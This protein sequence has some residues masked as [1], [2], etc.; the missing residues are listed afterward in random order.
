MSLAN[1]AGS[2]QCFRMTRQDGG[3]YRVIAFG[4]RLEIRQT[5]ER[6]FAFDCSRDEFDRV[7][8]GYFDLRTDYSPLAGRIDPG[9]RFLAAA[10]RHGDGLRILRQ[11]PWE[12]TVS[13]IISQ[14]KSLP[15]IRSAVEALC[16]RFGD[17]LEDRHGVYR[18]F[19]APG[20]IAG[21]RKEDLDACSLGYRS[22]YVLSAA[23][24]AASGGLDFGRMAALDDG[25]LRRELMRIDGVGPKIAD[26][27]MLF[28]YARTDAFPVDV[29]IDRVIR[30]EYGGRF[31]LER[32]PGC[33]GILQQYAFHY[34]RSRDYR[35]CEKPLNPEG[36]RGAH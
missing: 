10:L 34:A 27:V 28:A 3:A 20:R 22:G 19:P 9:D 17:A 1:I 26:C 35:I 24:M 8:S 33:A 7:W 14:R 36:Y 6:E 32:Y 25:D 29:W 18:A 5:G 15:C 13:F 11:D 2:G 31:P 4:K 12:T 16:R 30:T 23:R 21:L